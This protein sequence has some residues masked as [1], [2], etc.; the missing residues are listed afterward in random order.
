VLDLFRHHA[1]SV[2]AVVDKENRIV[3]VITADDILDLADRE[4]S[5]D[6]ELMAAMHPMEDGYL[7][8]SVW[9]HAKNRLPW[10][11]FLLL[12]GM[13]NG[14][15]LGG[16]EATFMLFP[17]L[18]TFIPM[19]TDTGGNAGSQSSTLVIRGLATG[20]LSL[21]DAWHV[22]RKE[23]AVSVLVG[24]GVALATFLRA[25]T[26][27]GGGL[28]VALTVSL[29]LLF[30]VIMSKLLGG[31][32]P[33]LAK[34]V[35]MDPALMAAPLVTTVVDALGLIVYFSVAKVFLNL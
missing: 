2:M 6:A 3:G 11:L 30:I 20:D 22:L 14:V 1:L 33:I 21:R 9:Q 12:S 32:L 35:G 31:I 26:M 4:A 7:E 15:I 5:E 28:G 23:L 8:T 25:Y 24:V 29:G 10:L 19:L 18:I 16:F 13:L 34:K 27:E 17:I